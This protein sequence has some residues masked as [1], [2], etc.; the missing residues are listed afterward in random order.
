M[1]PELVLRPEAEADAVEAGAA[2]AEAGEA[3]AKYR[4]YGTT[5]CDGLAWSRAAPAAVE[6]TT[7]APM[8]SSMRARRPTGNE[9]SS[10]T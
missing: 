5:T 3:D 4:S 6:T 9:G 2:E 1:S 7:P 8:S 10:G